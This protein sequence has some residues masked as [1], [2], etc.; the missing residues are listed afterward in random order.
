MTKEEAERRAKA[1]KRKMKTR[2]W[3]IHIWENIGWHY[4]IDNGFISIFPSGI[5]TLYFPMMST[6]LGDH[7]TPPY[8]YVNR[9]F[10]DPNEAVKVQLQY[11]KKFAEKSM[12]IVHEQFKLLGLKP[13]RK[14]L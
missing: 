7:A 1:L 9:L 3:V 8:W 14:T 11:A 13:R 5:D 6:Q 10:S 12:E 2:R 4:C